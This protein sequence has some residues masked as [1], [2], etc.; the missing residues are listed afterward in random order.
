MIGSLRG[1]LHISLLQIGF[2]LEFYLGD[3]GSPVFDQKGELLGIVI[4][5]KSS[6]DKAVFAVTSNFI[7]DALRKIRDEPSGL[8]ENHF[9]ANTAASFLN[10]MRKISESPNPLVA[11]P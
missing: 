2:G 5:G 1:G 7:S 3:S 4:A 8:F 6:G 11:A 9:E 10:R